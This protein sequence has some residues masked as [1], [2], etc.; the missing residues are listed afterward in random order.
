VFLDKGFRA[1]GITDVSAALGLSHGAIYTYARSKQALLYLALLRVL[2]PGRLDGLTVPVETPD[3]GTVTALA[4]SWTAPLPV[5]AAAA[6]DPAGTELGPVVDELYAFIEDKRIAL[7]LV[8]RCAADLPELAQW[9][10]VER[11]RAM[12]A[13]LGDYLAARIDLGLLNPVPDV[14]VAAR[15]VVETIAWFAMHRHGDPDS[16]MLADDDCRTGVRH[17][18]LTAFPPASAKERR[19]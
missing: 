9:Y 3:T 7:Q 10:F 5:L 14:P 19:S 12:I 4:E 11:R 15:F 16:A 18:L 17:L 6:A 13:R 2:D 8:E 1:A